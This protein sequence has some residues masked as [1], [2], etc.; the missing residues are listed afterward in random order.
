MIPFQIRE[1]ADPNHLFGRSDL[2][3]SLKLSA[4]RNANL[5]VVG[6]R[7][8]GKTCVMKS[9]VSYLKEDENT[10]VYPVYL[11]FKSSEISGTDNVYKYMIS[12]FL[13]SLFVDGINTD[14]TNICGND[15]MPSDIWEEI[16]EQITAKGLRLHRHFTEL[17][18]FFSELMEK[19]I[20]FIID[21][22]EFLFLK[23]LDKVE[24]FMK[25][26][27]LGA[28][29][30]NN[31]HR[32]FAYW[33]VGSIT[34]DKLCDNIGS[35]AANT[36]TETSYITPLDEESFF[37]WWRYELSFESDT[38]IKNLLDDNIGFAYERSGGVPYYGIKIA[39]YL[40]KH[41]QQPD[42]SVLLQSFK[43]MM[44]RCLSSE[45][46]SVLEKLRR[47]PQSISSLAANQLLQKGLIKKINKKNYYIKIAYLQDYLNILF[48]EKDVTSTDVLRKLVKE[49]VEHIKN[50]NDC[51]KNKSGRVVF[52][53]DNAMSSWEEIL[54]T[55]C[56]TQK[57]FESF[58]NSLYKMFFE[59]AKEK[60]KGDLLPNKFRYS[61]FAKCL[62]TA[63]H[64]VD[65]AQ[66]TYRVL[67]GQFTRP[68]MLKTVNGNVIEPFF[69]S[70]FYEF[71]LN[72]LKLFLNEL[73]SLL[74]YIRTH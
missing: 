65:H 43:D 8:F 51:Q 35:P 61:T 31:G 14:K 47:G 15:V 28:Q 72:F 71:Q 66:D 12:V 30:N 5:N 1:I 32:I 46:Q 36:I 69:S 44:S 74:E 9:L 26:R 63:R 10:T 39:E 11:D 68:E 70:E 56:K 7:R 54:R 18:S 17:V 38:N 37:K 57:D 59:R 73:K 60:D 55:E 24:G 23:S 22:Y 64:G 62:E 16:F 27:N 6:I 4:Y 48:S 34:W 13:S 33:L 19:T 42:Y 50:I 2:L 67:P 58:I 40:I 25:I 3:E 29:I 21:E 53:P 49:I 52:L 45:E 41:K 20:I